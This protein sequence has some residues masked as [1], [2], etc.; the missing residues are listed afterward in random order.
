MGG[1]EPTGELRPRAARAG[2]ARRHREQAALARRGAELFAAAPA[3]ACSSG[4]RR[5]LR[6]DPGHQ[7][8]ARVAR[9][10]ERP[11]RARD[12]QRDD[13]LHPHADGGGAAYEEALAEAQ[14]AR[15]TPRPTR[16]TTS[17]APTPRRRW[18][19]SR[20]S[21]SARASARGRRL[22]GHH[23]SAGARGG[24]PELDMV[25]R[26]VGAATLVDGSSTSASA[27]RSSAGTTRSPRSRAPSTP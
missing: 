18:R 21:R 7:G 3:A 24:G 20:P 16:P 5:G 19:S 9:R 15:A 26:L 17:P 6:G 14:R 10:H 22:P 2:Q 12:R 25:V 11:P 8:A 13:Q 4:S 27:P 1:V 23:E